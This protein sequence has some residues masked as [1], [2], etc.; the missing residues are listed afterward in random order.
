M[1]FVGI[2]VQI[3][4]PNI[5]DEELANT[6]V[7]EVLCS[8]RD[9]INF[10]HEMYRQAFLLNFTHSSAVHRVIALYKDLIQMNI[11]ELPSYL[12]E[13]PDGSVNL[14]EEFAEGVRPG[15]LRNDSYIGAVHKEN[16]LVRAGLQVFNKLQRFFAR[17]I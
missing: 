9:N 15:R 8:S 10:V 4:K 5:N 16:V 14:Q 3:Q 7:R 11:P 13:P 12:L 17:V 6:I 2:S 1:I